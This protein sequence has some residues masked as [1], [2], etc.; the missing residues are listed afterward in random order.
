MTNRVANKNARSYVQSRK[1]FT[2]SNLFGVRK[3]GLYAVCSFG[4]HWPLFIYDFQTR[5]WF[6]NTDRYSQTTSKHR[7]QVHPHC[8]TKPLSVEQ[9][10]RLYELGSYHQLAKDRLK[11]AA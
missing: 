3:D 7:G 1:E 8:E 4:L 2:G 10:C 6:E 11:C 5:T 9:M